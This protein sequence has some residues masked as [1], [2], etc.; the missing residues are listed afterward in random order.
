LSGLP[1]T[2]EVRPSCDLPLSHKTEGT[3]TS[4]I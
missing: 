2:A 4:F 1:S 3:I